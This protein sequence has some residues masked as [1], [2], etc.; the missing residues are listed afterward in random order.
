MISVNDSHG[1][2]DVDLHWPRNVPG[3]RDQRGNYAA[4]EVSRDDIM[5]S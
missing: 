4:L 1:T 3:M 2:T 5:A